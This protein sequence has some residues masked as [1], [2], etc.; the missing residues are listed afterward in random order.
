MSTTLF[1]ACGASVPTATAQPANATP[2]S[3]PVATATL[4]P[5]STPA[6]APATTQAPTATPDPI[7]TATAIASTPTP[8]TGVIE[9][10]TATPSSLP[11]LTP[12][13]TPTPEQSAPVAVTLVPTQDATIWEGEASK[14]SGA[15]ANLF[16]GKNNRGQARRALLQFDIAAAI[17]AGATVVS[18]SLSLSA[19]RTAASGTG[20]PLSLH[21]LS[22]S[23]GE[24]A[25][26]AG[27]GG[28]GATAQPGDVTWTWREFSTVAWDMAQAGGDFTSTSSGTSTTGSWASTADLVHDVQFWLD[29]PSTNHGW[30]IIG[31]EATNQSV[32]R[33]DSRESI[34]APVL[35]V[36]YVP[37][38]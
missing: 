8:A 11:V 15:G 6:P 5:T 24:G 26:D 32:R 12:T 1:L 20:A 35:I 17:P 28:S 14:A 18:A 29:D 9:P 2:T 4:V 3:S 30:I 23:W 37:G 38:S 33:L 27:T 19:N 36:T 13:P 10:P 21:T 25:S 7:P 34:A 31:D 22:L 16:A